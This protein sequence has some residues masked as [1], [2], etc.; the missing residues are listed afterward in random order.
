MTLVLRQTKASYELKKGGKKI[1]HLLFM[2]DL[3]LFAKIED[4]IDRLVNTVGIF[5]ED[6][7]MEFVLPKCGVLIM[8]GGKVAKSEGI[9]MLDGYKYLGILEADG[10]KH[11]EM[12]DQIKE[13]YIRRVRNILKSKL[14]GGNIILAINSRAVSIVRYGAG[15]ISWTKIELEEIDWRTRKLMT[16]YGTHHPK[17]DVDRLYL[18]RCEGGRGLLGLEYCV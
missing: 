17:A 6:I 1:N 7:K 18:Q 14:N 3:K 4:Q 13:E 11:E 16:M 12:K 5:S 2:D 10:V 8:K 15:I 9:S